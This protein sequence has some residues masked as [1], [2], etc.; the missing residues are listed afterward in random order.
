MIVWLILDTYCL[1]LLLQSVA[2]DSNL[3]AFVQS[4][5]GWSEGMERLLNKMCSCPIRLQD[6]LIINI[7]GT[8]QSVSQIFHIDLVT[9]KKYPAT[10][11]L[12]WSDEPRV[13]LV[14][15]G[16]IWPHWKLFRMK[17]TSVSS[18]CIS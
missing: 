11:G 16:V 4:A 12:V 14:G 13:N 7:S 6:S 9:K 3:P 2:P 5:F 17:E 8:K 15:L 18:S 10:I 1:R